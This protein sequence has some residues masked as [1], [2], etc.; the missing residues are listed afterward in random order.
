MS[1]LSS[2]S[3]RRIACVLLPLL[4]LGLSACSSGSSNDS[5]GGSASGTSEGHKL[6]NILFVNPLPKYPA[7]RAMGDCM[8]KEAA[9]LGISYQE[10]GSSSGNI[11]TTYEL[12]R[13]H[14]A[15]ANKYGAIM[16]FPSDPAQFGPVLK[17]ANKAGIIT[18][19]MW[20]GNNPLNNST[21]DVGP[22]FNGMAQKYVDSI[23]K[24]PGKQVVG[25]ISA[26]PTG[27]TKLFE[28]AFKKAAGKTSNVKV[29]GVVYTG[30]DASKALDAATNL[31]SAH[32]EINILASN[33]GTATAGSTSAIKQKNKVGK[34][35][36]VANGFANGALEG[37]KRGTVYSIYIQDI[38]GGG[39]AGIKAVA[40]AARGK[41]QKYTEVATKVVNGKDDLDGYVA[42]G[43]Q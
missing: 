12:A 19:T 7:W 15:I 26:A 6:Q 40:N 1:T 23:T 5:A 27:P 25:L 38:C 32:P 37:L 31:L 29:A 11:D 20:G 4:L 39:A 24:R 14:Q 35:F 18:A 16:V 34:V 22:D 33:L 3:A 17:Q 28:D 36:F 9:R 10:A 13:V 21:V 42:K 30:D 2:R 8:K 41:V 43:W